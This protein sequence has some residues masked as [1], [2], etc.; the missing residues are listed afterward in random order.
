M[1][2]AALMV[3][4]ARRG[5]RGEFPVSLFAALVLAIAPSPSAQEARAVPPS[6]PAKVGA[7]SRI[8]VLGASLSQGYGLELDVGAPVLFAD[9]VEGTLRVEHEPVR[10]QAALLFFASPLSSARNAVTAGKAF[11]PTLVVGIDFLFWFGYGAFPSEDDRMAMLEKGL[12][13][14]ETFSCPVLVGDFPDLGDASRDLARGG[15]KGRMLGAE[16][17]PQPESLARLNRRLREWAAAR[18]GVVVVPLGE[19]VARL[20]AGK[21]VE[22][23]GTRWAGP[24]LDGLLQKDRLHPTLRGAIALWFG[25]LDALVAAK[26]EIPSSAFDWDAEFVSRRIID[27]KAKERSA[28]EARARAGAR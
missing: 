4:R 28:L 19:F 2:L 12:A 24:A 26:P 6:A 18:K 7:L 1:E 25:A 22:I 9:V 3:E 14:L 5:L 27:A 20:H 8:L 15:A 17:V 11:D 10:S 23:H 21:D 16:Q 13:L